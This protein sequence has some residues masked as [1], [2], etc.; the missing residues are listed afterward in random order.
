MT[1]GYVY[2]GE[3]A[4]LNGK[5]IYCDFCS[6]QF[7]MLSKNE[8]DVWINED[9]GAFERSEY[10]AFG[11][12]VNGELYIASLF[13]GTIQ[14]IG[15]SIVDNIEKESFKE[16]VHIWPNPANDRVYIDFQE[17]K[18]PSLSVFSHS[19]I[20]MADIHWDVK[21]NQAEAIISTLI[22]G[23]YFISI[24]WGKKNIVRK[25]VKN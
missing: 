7:W 1:G 23:T 10:S 17:S 20:E 25:F 2:R 3:F 21:D 6:G 15:F 13:E 9:I 5:Y 8:E 14:K 18:T 19:G 22:P 4:F 12:D 16:Q 11:E 24:S